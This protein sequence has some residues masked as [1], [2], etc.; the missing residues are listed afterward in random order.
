MLTVTASCQAALRHHVHILDQFLFILAFCQEWYCTMH[1]FV[2]RVN[3]A[4]LGEKNRIR[5]YCFVVLNNKK[6]E[7]VIKE[8]YVRTVTHHR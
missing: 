1:G 2:L 7:I 8:Y 5:I 6:K 4:C 3:E